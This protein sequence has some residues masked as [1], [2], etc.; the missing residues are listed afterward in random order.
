M[1]YARRKRGRRGGGIFGGRRQQTG[2]LCDGCAS[3]VPLHSSGHPGESAK[4]EEPRTLFWRLPNVVRIERCVRAAWV[5][6]SKH[7]SGTRFSCQSC[8]CSA[9]WLL[10]NRNIPCEQMLWFLRR[11]QAFYSMIT[12]KMC[13]VFFSYSFIASLTLQFTLS[14][15]KVLH[16]STLFYSFIQLLCQLEQSL[17]A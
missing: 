14:Q 12:V 5:K 4:R 9:W 11:S 8:L 3:L 7:R 13:L 1:R 6:V 2:I 10:Y 16:L 15:L 17:T